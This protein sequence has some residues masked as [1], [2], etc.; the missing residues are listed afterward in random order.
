MGESSESNETVSEAEATSEDGT[1]YRT[2]EI[3][4]S[5]ETSDDDA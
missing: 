3:D 5:G 2:L 1:R 4:K